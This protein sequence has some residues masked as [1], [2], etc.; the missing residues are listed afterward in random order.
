MNKWVE[1]TYELNTRE[2]ERITG[3]QIG[4]FQNF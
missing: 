1:L 4:N 2:K 3:L